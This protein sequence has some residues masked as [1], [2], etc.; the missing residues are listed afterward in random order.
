ME[1]YQQVVTYM[2]N[3]LGEAE[4]RIKRKAKTL[5]NKTDKKACSQALQNAVKENEEMER[6]LKKKR[7]RKMWS[8]KHPRPRSEYE[9]PF[10]RRRTDSTNSE[11]S[12][13]NTSRYRRNTTEEP[14]HTE[15]TP[16]DTERGRYRRGGKAKRY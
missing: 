3:E 7:A 9:R 10:K 5:G 14:T 15:D 2:R 1:H 4:D 16:R 12:S 8:L 6:D 11:Q 13:N